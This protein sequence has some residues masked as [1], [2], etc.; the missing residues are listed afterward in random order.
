MTN[1]TNTTQLSVFSLIR[2]SLL[3]NSTLSAKFNN[4]NI[5]QYEPKHKSLGFG[6]F[7]Y[8]WI[9]IP[10][11]AD[12]HIVINNNFTLKTVNTSLILRIE[13]QARDKFLSYAN[14]IISAVE[15]YDNTF[16]NSGYFHVKCELLN[17]D[18]NSII[19]EKEIV[20]GV[21]NITFDGRVSR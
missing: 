20:E 5:Y 12:E 17:V 16:D 9:N 15:A 6:G 4:S 7:P 11:L 3:A 13:Y 21:F 1:I 10:E 8:I 18:S 14:A 19:Q 2:T